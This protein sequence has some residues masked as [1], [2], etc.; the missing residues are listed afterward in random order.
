MIRN[1]KPN[2]TFKPYLG[3]EHN[4]F[5]MKESGEINYEIFNWDKVGI[6]WLNWLKQ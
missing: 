2:F 5:P 4:Y 6:D 1:N 3:L